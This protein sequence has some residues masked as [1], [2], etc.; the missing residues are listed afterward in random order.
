MNG[1]QISSEPETPA[2]WESPNPDRPG[3]DHGS[4]KISPVSYQQTVDKD[5]VSNVDRGMFH[6]AK[7]FLAATFA[8][9][10][11]SDGGGECLLPRV[12]GLRPLAGI[13]LERE[14]IL[15]QAVEE[16]P[17]AHADGELRHSRLGEND[18]ALGE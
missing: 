2:S 13:V 5:H 3:P 7:S 1:V 4:R 18:R 9:N 17:A 11:C 10:E 6:H 14:G 12:R 8:G 16:A 15:G